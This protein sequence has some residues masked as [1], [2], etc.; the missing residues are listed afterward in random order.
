MSRK[1]MMLAI[2]FSLATATV[3]STAFAKG[4][5]EPGDDRGRNSG[6]GKFSGPRCPKVKP[7]DQTAAKGEGQQPGDDRGN[8]PQ[9][10]TTVAST[11]AKAS[12]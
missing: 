2:C 11:A 3:S 12:S 9:P 8:H 10:A 7:V 4:Q 1:S 5:P 6:K